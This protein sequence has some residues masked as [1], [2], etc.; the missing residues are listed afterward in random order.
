MQLTEGEK[1]RI[2][3]AFIEHG[4]DHSLCTRDKHGHKCR[5]MA[6]FQVMEKILEKRVDD[7]IITHV[8]TKYDKRYL[9]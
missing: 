9:R 1:K 3:R 4:F 8:T 2:R 7:A 6:G 5:A